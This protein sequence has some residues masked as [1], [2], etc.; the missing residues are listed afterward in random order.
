MNELEK[1]LKVLEVLLLK[2][3]DENPKA[4]IILNKG[5]AEESRHKYSDSLIFLRKIR[6]H[7]GGMGSCTLGTCRECKRNDKRAI[8]SIYNFFGQCSAQ[9]GKTID[10]FSSCTKFARDSV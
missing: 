5:T 9:N 8:H 4:G 6:M 7:F 2:R 3:L 1:E 10:D